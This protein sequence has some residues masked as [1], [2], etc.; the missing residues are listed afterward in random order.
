VAVAKTKERGLRILLRISDDELGR[1]AWE[2]ANVSG[3]WP[4]LDPLTPMVRYVNT[5]RPDL[6]QPPLDQLRILGLIGGSQATI[7]DPPL[8]LMKEKKLL[9]RALDTF[10]QTGQIRMHWLEGPSILDDLRKALRTWQPHVIHF[11]GHGY[12]DS[13]GIGLG[14]F[15]EDV[16][17]NTIPISTDAL[18]ILLHNTSVRFAFLN[19]CGTGNPIIGIAQELVKTCLP[20]ALGMHADIPD[21]AAIE[22]SR[23]F[24]EALAELMPVDVAMTE[25]RIRL[26]TMPNADRLIWAIP[27]LYMHARDGH[28]FRPVM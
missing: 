23:S 20:A 9:H 25:G 21:H 13:Q 16:D 7:N 18:K 4:S 24:Y 26:A 12:E 27:T 14:L 17:G 15:T 1:V 3:H 22:F 10:I 6:R 2:M 11:I 5:N 19:A 8:D 28:L